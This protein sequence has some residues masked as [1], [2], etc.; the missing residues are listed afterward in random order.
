MASPG[1]QRLWESGGA[2]AAPP[3]PPQGPTDGEAPSLAI[4]TQRR[5]RRSGAGVSLGPRARLGATAAAYVVAG[6]L[7]GLLLSALGARLF[8]GSGTSP[9]PPIAGAEAAEQEETRRDMLEQAAQD[10][11]V[12]ASAGGSASSASGT[13]GSVRLADADRELLRREMERLA[14]AGS[15]CSPRSWVAGAADAAPA[16]AAGGTAPAPVV[17][18]RVVD[19]PWGPVCESN[20]PGGWVMRQPQGLRVGC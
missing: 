8:A 9:E 13:L 5:K 1:R 7:G 14:V 20:V 2:V 6:V 4:Y 17:A 12:L 19:E 16:D 18:Q 3:A 15:M 11:P 10:P